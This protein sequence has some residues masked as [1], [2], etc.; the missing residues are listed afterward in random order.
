[1]A[2]VL[3]MEFKDIVDD[4]IKWSE[5]TFGPGPRD[6]GLID[7]I[8]KELQEIAQ[9]P[10][11]IEEWIDVVILAIDGAWRHGFTGADIENTLLMKMEKNRN[12][13]WP[14]W[15]TAAGSKAIEHIKCT[16]KIEETPDGKI[17][18]EV[19]TGKVIS[20]VWEDIFAP[21][22][23]RGESD[24]Y[25]VVDECG[26]HMIFHKDDTDTPISKKWDL[27]WPN[28]LVQG[29]SDYY[30]AACK[31]GPIFIFHKDNK[32]NYVWK[33][34]RADFHTAIKKVLRNML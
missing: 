27:I 4:Q 9:A 17:I 16:Y 20:R 32:N 34:E 30:F 33:G 18:K 6:A 14:D 29:K 1:M 2:G 21:G 26:K 5:S 8:R 15:R 25:L 7:H 10:G 13:T 28:G 3:I 11:D 24:Y 31:R 22:L 23:L 12:R 19:E